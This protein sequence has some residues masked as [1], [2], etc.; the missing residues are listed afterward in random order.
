MMKEGGQK[1]QD[2]TPFSPTKTNSLLQQI[3]DL[4]IFETNAH[5]PMGTFPSYRENKR[6]FYVRPDD[7]IFATASTVFILNE[8]KGELPSDERQIVEK[9]IQNARDAYSLYQNKDGLDTYN[10]WKTRP[11]QH[12]P[13]GFV[14]NKI[15]HFKLPDDID[16][17]ALIYL[18]KPHSQEQSLW[19]K[20]KLTQHTQLK[21]EPKRYVYSTWF[22]ENMPIEQDVCA[23]C[24]LMYWVFEN[25][26]P[27]T[28]HDEKTVG[29]LREKILSGDF[30]KQPFQT[31]RHYA[32]VPLILY[33]YARLIY[34]FDVEQLAD[35][36]H[37]IV[38]ETTALLKGDCSPTE[39]VLLSTVL[40][41]LASEGEVWQ[42][43]YIKD[44]PRKDNSFYSFIGAFVAP[45]S[46]NGE[47]RMEN[48]KRSGFALF[49]RIATHPLTRFSW[50]CEAHEL[51]LQLEYQTLWD[52]KF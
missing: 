6:L 27:F 34:K 15:R 10:F 41:K 31:A 37:V 42:Q 39:R 44:E 32:T 43:G 1:T 20:E 9:I 17:T 18:T 23:L 25:E 19:L 29:F 36:K 30:K 48:G 12:F 49:Q 50:N 5:F 26:L 51:A 35:C 38:S 47:W 22:G 40:L 52:K 11:S 14:L 21:N 28:E 2:K 4:Q 16:D 33:H 8:I 3:A 7:N 13:H 24:N 45:Y 46:G